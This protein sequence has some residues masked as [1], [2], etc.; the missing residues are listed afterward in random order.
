M[1]ASTAPVLTADQLATGLTYPAYRQHSLGKYLM[2]LKTEYARRWQLDYYYPGYLVHGYPKFDYQLFVDIAATEVFHHAT[3]QWQP[4]S[5]A[6]VDEHSAELFAAAPDW[7]NKE[8]PP[9][10]GSA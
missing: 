7:V 1:P 4:F 9:A 3:S 2:L 8:Q 5:W 6:V 10:N